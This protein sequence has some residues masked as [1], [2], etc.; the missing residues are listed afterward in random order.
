MV[1]TIADAIGVPIELGL[2]A[3]TGAGGPFAFLG[4]AKMVKRK[5]WTKTSEGKFIAWLA[6]TS[7]VAASLRKAGMTGSDPYAHRM[8]SETF[9]GAWD[10]ALN[11]GYAELEVQA[12]DEARN[13][14]TAEVERSPAGERLRATLLNAHAKR[15]G[16]VRDVAARGQAELAYDRRA[17]KVVLHVAG[18]LG[19]TL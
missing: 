5:S 13:G 9:R 1:S 8:K 18:L 4:V 6:R 14:A 10:A 12:L 7:N 17:R 16:G 15:V 2:V 3:P 19:I 11:E